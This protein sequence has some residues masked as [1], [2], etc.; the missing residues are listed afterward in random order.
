[1]CLTEELRDVALECTPKPGTQILLWVIQWKWS[2]QNPY[3]Q[4]YSIIHLS[5]VGDAVNMNNG[6]DVYLVISS[7]D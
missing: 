1:M 4:W 7:S 5:L 3:K 2:S 6:G